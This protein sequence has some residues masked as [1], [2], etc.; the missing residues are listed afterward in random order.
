MLKEGMLKSCVFSC[1][2]VGAEGRRGRGTRCTPARPSRPGR[3]RGSHLNDPSLCEIQNSNCKHTK[4][5]DEGSLC[6]IT[7]TKK[8]CAAERRGSHLNGLSL[9]EHKTALCF[10]LQAAQ[11]CM[12]TSLFCEELWREGVCLY[13]RNGWRRKYCTAETALVSAG[14]GN[15]DSQAG[16]CRLPGQAMP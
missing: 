13:C 10:G 12:G 16:H 1:T 14:A 6:H 3:G 8:N 7:S 15:Y 9:C 4:I 5:Q 11:W 2:C